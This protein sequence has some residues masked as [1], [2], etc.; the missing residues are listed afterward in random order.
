MNARLSRNFPNDY[1]YFYFLL[2]VKPA[3]IRLKQVTTKVKTPDH[4]SQRTFCYT[5]SDKCKIHL[6]HNGCQT[7]ILDCKQEILNEPHTKIVNKKS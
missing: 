1:F 2:N 4:L 6:S 5:I 7:E 3:V